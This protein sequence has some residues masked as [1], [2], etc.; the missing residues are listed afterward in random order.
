MRAQEPTR[1][2]SGGRGAGGARRG[3]GRAGRAGGAE[4]G[5]AT[6]RTPLMSPPWRR[7]SPRDSNQA[8]PGRRTRPP[9]R[10]PPARRPSAPRR[11]PPRPGRAR[12]AGGW[13]SARAPRRGA[14]RRGRR[15]PR[16][17]PR[18]R[19]SAARGRVPGA[20]ASGPAASASRPPAATDELEAGE[21]NA[22]DHRTH[23]RI[24]GGR[25]GRNSST[26]PSRSVR[27][28]DRS[29]GEY[30]REIGEAP[31]GASPV[32]DL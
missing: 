2:R 3:R 32:A 7:R 27:V 8:V 19:R 24:A 11:R 6:A 4:R 13:G 20:R 9:R 23:V 25:Q 22:D 10:C 18:P 14:G 30:S 5:R 29:D 12:R 15:R 21:E 17:R 16:R 28:T 1:A 31:R 26:I